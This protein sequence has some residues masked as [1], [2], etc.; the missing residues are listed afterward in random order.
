MQY[1][2]AKLLRQMWKQIEETMR[3]P[4]SVG[5]KA[6]SNTTAQ[7]RFV[8]RKRSVSPLFSPLPSLPPHSFQAHHV[9]HSTK[10]D[11]KHYIR[12][13]APKCDDSVPITRASFS[14]FFSYSLTCFSVH[15]TGIEIIHAKTDLK[16]AQQCPHYTLCLCC[17]G[18]C[19]HM[20]TLQSKSM[21]RRGVNSVLSHQDTIGDHK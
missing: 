11:I 16:A 10:F 2:T 9:I 17:F 5:A 12:Y 19:F 6:E 13:K 8:S 14:L 4:R 3:W 20:L 7:S 18:K 15:L 21:L 1:K